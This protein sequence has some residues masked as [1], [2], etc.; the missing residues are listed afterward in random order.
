MNLFRRRA[1]TPSDAGRMLAELA[2]LNDRER[3]KARARQM[4]EAMGLPAS[5]V[6]D[7]RG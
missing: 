4:R 5:P 2:C 7:P 3:Y 6:L 1:P